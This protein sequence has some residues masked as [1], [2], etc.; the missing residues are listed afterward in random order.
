MLQTLASLRR[1]GTIRRSV[2]TKIRLSI[3]LHKVDGLNAPKNP[4]SWKYAVLKCLNYLHSEPTACNFGFLAATSNR[5][6]SQCE[7]LLFP[8]QKWTCFIHFQGLSSRWLTSMKNIITVIADG[9]N[10]ML[11]GENTTQLPFIK[12]LI[13]VCRKEPSQQIFLIQ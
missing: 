4:F 6:S 12:S 11:S 2:E 8:H 13:T 9:I 10:D 3:I 1:I 7:K 5:V